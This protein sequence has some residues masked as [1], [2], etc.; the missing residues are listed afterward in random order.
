M[1]TAD[2][3]DDFI[4]DEPITPPID[5]EAEELAGNKDRESKGQADQKTRL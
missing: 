5:D 1:T 4:I 2:D 3:F